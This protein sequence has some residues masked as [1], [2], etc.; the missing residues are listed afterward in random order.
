MSEFLTNNPEKQ[1]QLK[2]ITQKLHQGTS[3][4]EVKRDFGG[5]IK[6]LDDMRNIEVKHLSGA[7]RRMI[8][9]EEK[10]FPRSPGII[11]RDVQNC[12][13][14]KS[15]HSVNRI[16]DALKNKEKERSEFW[17]TRNGHFIHILY[18]PMYDSGDTYRGTL[19]VSQDA[20]DIRNLEGER[21]LLDW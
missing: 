15:V 14:Q 5:P 6:A 7:I 13:P 18:I 9:M 4:E 20:T 16:L 2:A 19:E 17:L 1:E 21:C 8:F 10:I 11:G 3:V 12:H